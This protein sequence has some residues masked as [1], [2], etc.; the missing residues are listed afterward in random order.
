MLLG[1][2]N[3]RLFSVSSHTSENSL[4]RSSHWRR[5]L[6]LRS[7]CRNSIKNCSDTS[8]SWDLPCPSL[9]LIK[10]L[11]PLSVDSSRSVYALTLYA[12]LLS[13]CKK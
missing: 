8:N 10:Y 4:C 5:F 12:I 6:F 1:S 7:I 2:F 13:S 9:K 3:A 11:V